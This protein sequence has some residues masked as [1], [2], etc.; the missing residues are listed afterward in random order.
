MDL[1]FR[2]A[3]ADAVTARRYQ[4]EGFDDILIWTDY[5]WPKAQPLEVK[6]AAISEAAAALGL[7]PRD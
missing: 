7:E 6:Q 2:V 1:V 5:V 4:D 3:G